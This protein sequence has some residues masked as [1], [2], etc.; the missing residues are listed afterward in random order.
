MSMFTQGLL[1]EP[2]DGTLLADSGALPVG[3]NRIFVAISS[4]YRGRIVLAHRNALNDT[5][6][7]THILFVPDGPKIFPVPAFTTLLNERLVARASG[8]ISGDVQVT[9]IW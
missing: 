8:S 4:E 2:V 1:T 3:Q 6:L 5:D 7:S 9:I